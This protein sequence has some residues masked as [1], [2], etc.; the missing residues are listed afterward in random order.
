MRL[1][2]AAE[3][4]TLSDAVSK[5]FG[6]ASFHLVV[7]SDQHSILEALEHNHDLPGHGIERFLKWNLEGVIAGNVGPAAFQDMK[8]RRLSV[9]IVRGTTVQQA[10]LQVVNG[11]I[12]AADGP[13][14]KHSI[15]T[16]GPGSGSKHHHRS[17]HSHGQG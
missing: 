2:V 8:A 6:H 17:G 4:S 3:G 15:H 11:E 16:H 5:R 1:L 14:M 9:Y 10:V 12:A 13:T 7:D